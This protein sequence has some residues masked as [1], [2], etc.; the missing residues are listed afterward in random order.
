MFEWIVQSFIDAPGVRE[1]MR[2][3]TDLR[4]F[5]RHFEFSDDGDVYRRGRE[6]LARL[7]EQQRRIDPQGRIWLSIIPPAHGVP[8]PEIAS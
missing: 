8:G 2:Y 5:D 6:A 7:R 1:R 3:E 4:R